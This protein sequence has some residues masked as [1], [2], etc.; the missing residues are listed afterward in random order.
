[1]KFRFKKLVLA[2]MVLALTSTIYAQE[3]KDLEGH[4]SKD[5]IYEALNT[6]KISGYPDGSFKPDINMTRAE[7]IKLINSTLDINADDVNIKASDT[8]KDKW[9]YIELKKAIKRKYIENDE[10]LRPEDA[11]S[12]QEAAYIIGRAYNFSQDPSFA[13]S[14]KDY[15]KIAVK[16][17][18]YV[19]E[20]LKEK[21]IDGFKDSSFKPDDKLTRAQACV[22]LSKLR[23]N[24][25][26]ISNSIY[27]DG[28]KHSEY[29]KKNDTAD[30]D[31]SF[32]SKA[33]YKAKLLIKNDYTE[34][35]WTDFEKVLM[36]AV[37]VYEDTNTSQYYIDTATQS[38]NEAFKELQPIR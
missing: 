10:K 23:T 15:D 27:K 18:G 28:N 13:S 21:I 11:I 35:S 1:M 34:D 24:S 16:N 4:W 36:E 17:R 2:S 6:V 22:I 3:F 14:F 7:F 33:I 30:I 38:L 29:D 31:K 37:K 5:Y 9:Y 19:G 20:L 8:P 32:L 25:F 12:R 26:F